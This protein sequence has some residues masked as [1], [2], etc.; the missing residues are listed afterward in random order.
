MNHKEYRVVFACVCSRVLVSFLF[1]S[2]QQHLDTSV[3]FSTPVTSY[4]SLQEGIFLLKNNLPVFNGGVVHQSPLLIILMSLITN[5]FLISV[6]YSLLDGLIAYQLML[7]ANHFKKQLKL[8][9][10]IVGSL[11]TVNPLVMLSCL[12]RSSV[13]F[14][15][16]AI[17]TALLSALQGDFIL[18]SFSISCAGYLSLYPLLLIIPMLFVL[19][20]NRAKALISII[21]SLFSSLVISYKINNKNWNYLAS[22]YGVLIRFNKMIP[23]LGLWWYFFIEMF[24]FFIPFFKAIFNLFVVSFIIPFTL[25][26]YRQPFYAFILCLGWITLTKS[27]P[28]LGDGGFFISFIPFFQPLFG[29]LR[30]SVMST[31]LFLHTLVLSPIFYY[32]WVDLGSGNSNFFYAISLVYALALTSVIINL[33]WGMLRIEYDHGNPNLNIKLTQI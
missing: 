33:C 29:Y 14:T 15:N 8:N 18:A 13:T 1:P 3:E 17:S 25:R 16:L 11:Y 19:D 32:L 6:F 28:T 20:N 22:T 2:L 12:S 24:E 5:D 9:A 30:Y 4:R 10:W 31:L 21:M 27:Y 7:M 26:F 23:N